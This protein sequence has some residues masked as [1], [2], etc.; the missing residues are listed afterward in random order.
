MQRTLK[1]AMADV[2][3]ENLTEQL[4][5][6]KYK[7]YRAYLRSLDEEFL[8]YEYADRIGNEDGG[9]EWLMEHGGDPEVIDRLE[10]WAANALFDDPLFHPINRKYMEA[11]RAKL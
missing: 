8:A 4:I 11:C 9:Y 7:C 2:E 6:I 3:K 10:D 1:E 5:Q